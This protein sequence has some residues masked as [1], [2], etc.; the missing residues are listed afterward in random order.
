MQKRLEDIIYPKI[1]W[2]AKICFCV[3]FTLVIVLLLRA[4]GLV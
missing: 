2:D 1:G 4:K 3:V